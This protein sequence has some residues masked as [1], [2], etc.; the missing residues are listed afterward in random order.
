MSQ[1]Q[2]DE[3]L[4]AP[5]PPGGPLRTDAPAGAQTPGKPGVPGSEADDGNDHRDEKTDTEE[6][7]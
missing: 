1:K 5:T 3:P 7:R 6:R 2:N 4:D